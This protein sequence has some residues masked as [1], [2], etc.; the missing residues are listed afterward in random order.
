MVKGNLDGHL[1]AAVPLPRRHRRLPLPGRAW[2][3]SSGTSGQPQGGNWAG[4]VRRSLWKA[5]KP[6]RSAGGRAAMGH[7]A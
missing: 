6:Y 1:R 7:Q 3:K 4:P 2:R 5:M